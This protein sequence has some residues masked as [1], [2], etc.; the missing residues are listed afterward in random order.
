MARPSK[1]GSVV[2]EVGL[3][4]ANSLSNNDITPST[5]DTR[6]TRENVWVE[7]EAAI[8]QLIEMLVELR[9]KGRCFEPITIASVK[10]FKRL[11]GIESYATKEKKVYWRYPD[12]LRVNLERAGIDYETG[13]CVN[14]ERYRIALKGMMQEEAERLAEK[15]ERSDYESRREALR[16]AIRRYRP[17]TRSAVASVEHYLSNQ[18]LNTRIAREMRGKLEE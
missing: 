2:R 11:L 8:L 1:K 10:G 16:E 4:I 15:Y 7:E 17:H 18:V 12:E 13:K 3:T 9:R 14:R 5:R 6:A